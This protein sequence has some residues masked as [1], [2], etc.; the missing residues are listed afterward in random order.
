[1]RVEHYGRIIGLGKNQLQKYKDL[2]K[3]VP[4]LYEN[5]LSES[6]IHNTTFYHVPRP[7]GE[8]DYIFAHMEYTGS[9]KW[10]DAKRVSDNPAAKEWWSTLEPLE[11]PLNP[12][13]LSPS[14]GGTAVHPESDWWSACA[15][16]FNVMSPLDYKKSSK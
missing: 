5:A 9:V 8:K 4:K 3:N 12:K 16:V 11:E 1:M 10:E 14:K 2:H 13:A 6:S 15:P 7:D